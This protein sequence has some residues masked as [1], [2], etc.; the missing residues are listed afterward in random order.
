MVGAAKKPEGGKM[1][2]EALLDLRRRLSTLNNGY[3]QSLFLAEQFSIDHGPQLAKR[4]GAF[5]GEVFAANPYAKS[6][7]FECSLAEGRISEFNQIAFASFFVF[8]CSAFE[9]YLEGLISLVEAITSKISGINRAHGMSL[10]EW[11]LE[12]LFDLLNTAINNELSRDERNTIDYLR[13][14]RNSLIHSDGEPSRELDKLSK[15]AGEHLNKYWQSQIGKLSTID[16]SGQKPKSFKDRDIVDIHLIVV[17]LAERID[18]KVFSRIEID[19]LVEHVLRE[20]HK[21]H[22]NDLSQRSRH[23]CEQLFSKV[24]KEKFGL[25]KRDFDVEALN[26]GRA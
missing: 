17:E 11:R 10:T 12:V 26:L 1:R 7:N 23:R 6:F 5:T 14:R 15:K 2:S 9:L 3:C 25:G 4:H 21:T 19:R 16:F 20:V 24:A 22:A 8:F 18:A 13:L